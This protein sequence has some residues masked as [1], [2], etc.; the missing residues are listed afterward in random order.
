ML[1]K[2]FTATR[3]AFAATSTLVKLR[4]TNGPLEWTSHKLSVRSIRVKSKDLETYLKPDE[5]EALVVLRAFAKISLDKYRGYRSKKRQ[6][7]GRARKRAERD[8]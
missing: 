6:I 7:L 8:K 3:M 5:R 1:F 2:A 4:P